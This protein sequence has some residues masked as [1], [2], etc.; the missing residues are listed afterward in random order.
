M[1]IVSIC[2]AVLWLLL[3]IT[4]LYEVFEIPFEL[5]NPLI[6]PTIVAR[7]QQAYIIYT[8][9]NFIFFLPFLYVAIKR[10]QLAKIKILGTIVLI[11]FATI[12]VI[13]FIRV[14]G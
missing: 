10:R 8:I 5:S 13:S 1:K 11:Y 14:N 4:A 3:T 9:I 7:M 2:L 12:L 6:P